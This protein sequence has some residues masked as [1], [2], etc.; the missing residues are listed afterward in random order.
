MI[1]GRFLLDNQFEK[2]LN[3]LLSDIKNGKFHEELNSNNR[4]SLDESEFKELNSVSN[5]L[6]KIL[7]NRE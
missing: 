6:L 5:Q 4:Q 1:K 3:I 2:K 7:K